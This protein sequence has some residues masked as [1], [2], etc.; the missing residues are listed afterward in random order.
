MK[1]ALP[2][3]VIARQEII[4]VIHLEALVTTVA[5]VHFLVVQAVEILAEFVL[6]A[7]AEEDLAAAAAAVAQAAPAA[8][9]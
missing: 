4:A 6:A 7:V 8:A 3:V 9:A 5:E 1:T 2:E